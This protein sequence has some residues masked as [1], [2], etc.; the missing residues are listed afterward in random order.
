[1]LRGCSK[2]SSLSSLKTHSRSGYDYV[3]LVQKMRE[4]FDNER[5]MAVHKECYYQVYDPLDTAIQNL[6]YA[7]L[8]TKGKSVDC[9]G[10]NPYHI[11][12]LSTRPHLFFFQTI[13]C[14]QPKGGKDEGWTMH[15]QDA[16]GSTPLDHLLQNNAPE[17]PESIQYV[18][19]VIF[20]K[21]IQSLGLV[22]W[23][24]E[25][26]DGIDQVL[27]LAATDV[28]EARRPERCRSLYQWLVSKLE[29]LERK[30]SLSLLEMALW[31]FKI[32]EVSSALEESKAAVPV[33]DRLGCRVNCGAGIVI[34]NV[35][36]F[37]GKMPVLPPQPS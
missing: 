13:E 8:E 34:A 18:M 16:T 35:L 25:I 17:A 9:L 26:Q 15:C 36:P 37:L 2:L 22:K 19:Q 20:Q 31:R 30:E 14:Y 6:I 12:A 23:Q 1:M 5:T 10:M 29:L 21:R 33:V 24:Q 32:R 7:I 27:A 3:D 28:R 11:L 4:R